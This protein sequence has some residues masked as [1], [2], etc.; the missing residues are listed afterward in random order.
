ML[1]VNTNISSL[2]AQR[3]LLSNSQGA[4]VAMERL[5]SGKRIN[6]AKD[7]AAGLAISN[8]LESQIK[9]VTQ[10]I[11]TVSYTHLTLPTT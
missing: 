1:S 3:S 11:R 8:R 6:S 9:G 4:A 5:A 2:N 7:N 10:G